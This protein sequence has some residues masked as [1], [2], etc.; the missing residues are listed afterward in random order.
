MSAEKKNIIQAFLRYIKG[1][2]TKDD[3]GLLIRD[4]PSELSS[5][6]IRDEMDK[7]WED[8]ARI[9]TSVSKHAEY[10]DEAKKLLKRINKSSHRIDLK[11]F[12]R[13]AAAVAIIILAGAAFYFI[14]DNKVEKEATLAVLEVENGKRKELTLSDGTK[15]ILNS[16]TSLSYPEQFG[17]NERKIYLNGEAFLDVAIDKDRPFIVKTTH[18]EIKVLGTS[19]NIN[20]YEKDDF[21]TVTVET[22][23]V[24]VDLE[25]AMMQLLPTE[26]LYYNKISDSFTKDKE[27]LEN[28]KLW[29][30]GG[31][32]F[33]RTPIQDVAKELMRRFDCHIEFAKDEVFDEY[34]YGTH[35]GEDLEAI[36]N[37]ISYTTGIYY[38]KTGN[39]VV[40]TKKAGK[41]TIK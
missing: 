21:L 3:A 32:Y 1:C 6:P 13:Y 20:A 8:S 34:I 24:Q 33:N 29:M 19:F 18:A 27:D 12:F 23:K 17:G 38:K 2:Y 15:I 5:K 7:I 14:T 35:D 30:S 31:M 16:G 10:E 25:N 26:R 28:T 41:N 36:L 9:G 40:L 37:A 4:L 22:G 39:S 11:P